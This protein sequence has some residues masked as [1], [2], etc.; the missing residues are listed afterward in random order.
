MKAQLSPE[1]EEERLRANTQLVRVCVRP[2]FL[3][4]GDYDDLFQEGML[5]L[6]SALRTYDESRGS[7]F[8]AYAA[9][10]IRR[11]VID[12]VRRDSALTARDV[13]MGDPQGDPL[14]AED[15]LSDPEVSILANETA[16]EI[17]A[18]L[19]GM[20]SPFEVSVLDR[21]LDGYTSSEIADQL[22]RSRKSVD[23]AI[24]RIRRKLALYLSDRR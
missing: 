17:Q 10:C 20:L 22:Q 21:F 16:K 12:A 7:S 24:R 19:S 23:N 18:S 6:L 15:A 5:G 1:Q 3:R 2:Y 13:Y 8:Q 14:G 11:R 9:L 4:G